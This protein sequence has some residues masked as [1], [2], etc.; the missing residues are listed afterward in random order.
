MANKA[1]RNEIR[2]MLWRWGRWPSTIN[3]LEQQR[4][5]LLTWAAEALETVKKYNMAETEDPKLGEM[6]QKLMERSDDY[7]SRAEDAERRISAV[8]A[9][10]DA[11]DNALLCLSAKQAEVI[12]LRYRKRRSWTYTSVRME[13]SEYHL[14]HV[15]GQAVDV[16]A[17]ALAQDQPT[18]KNI[19]S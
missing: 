9:E 4:N 12:D 1:Q 6:V 18:E 16:I 10:R 17:D 14:M 7:L 3:R 15:E 2:A 8:L 13:Q 19:K 11:V 5:S